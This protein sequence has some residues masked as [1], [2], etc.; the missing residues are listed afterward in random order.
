MNE[1]HHVLSILKI[2]VQEA[3]RNSL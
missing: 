3:S 2:H 1:R